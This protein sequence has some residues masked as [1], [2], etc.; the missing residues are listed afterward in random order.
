MYTIRTDRIDT[1]ILNR[2]LLGWIITCIPGSTE[3][4][5]SQWRGEEYGHCLVCDAECLSG[6]NPMPKVW[7]TLESCR[8]SVYTG[9]PKTLVLILVKE[10]YNNRQM[11]LQQERGQAGKQQF[12]SSICFHVGSHQKV[13]PR[14][15][16]ALVSNILNKKFLTGK[17]SSLSFSGF[18]MQWSWQ[19]PLASTVPT[20]IP[21]YA[22]SYLRSI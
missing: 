19:S 20:G 12:P 4:A 7:R 5:D 22:E 2:D 8:S 18:Q 10:R 9:I 17:F 13:W 1:N 21:C 14:S 3:M 16:M 11:D 6:H 15:V